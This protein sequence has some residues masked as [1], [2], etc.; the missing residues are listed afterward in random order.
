MMLM[1]HGAIGSP[2]A[3]LHVSL[4][5]QLVH[6]RGE[7]RLSTL[8]QLVADESGGRRPA[9]DVILARLLEVLL[10]EALR[11]TAGDDASPGLLRGLVDDSFAD[12]IR[13]MY[14]HTACAV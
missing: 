3:A 2:D 5:P 8:V 12:V 14:E 7:K 1:C 10:I 4:L 6:I 9:R 13:A 11:S